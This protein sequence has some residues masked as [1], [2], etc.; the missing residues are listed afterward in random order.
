MGA[1]WLFAYAISFSFAY[2]RLPAGTGALILF[3]VVQAT[4]TG[5]GVARGERPGALEWSG[6]LIS[7][8]GLGLLFTAWPGDGATGRVERGKLPPRGPAHA[9]GERA[10]PRARARQ[11]ARAHAR[12]GLRRGRPRHRLRPLGRGAVGASP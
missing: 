4:M 7:V 2:L 5:A 12:G 6:L 8:C 9:G 11:L 10:H 1:L 3:G